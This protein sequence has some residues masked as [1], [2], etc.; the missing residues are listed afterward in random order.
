[1]AIFFW[2]KYFAIRENEEKSSVSAATFCLSN[3]IDAM[4]FKGGIYYYKYLSS[5]IY[6]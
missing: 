3:F 4:Y 1:M 2:L 5:R 6:Y